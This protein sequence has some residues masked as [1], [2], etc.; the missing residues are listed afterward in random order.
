MFIPTFTVHLFKHS[1]F[2]PLGIAY[3]EFQTKEAAKRVIEELNNTK[4]QNRAVV[5][6]P[7]VPFVSRKKFNVSSETNDFEHSLQ[8]T[9]S[10]A[11]SAHSTGIYDKLSAGHVESNDTLFISRVP[12][13]VSISDIQE[14]FDGYTAS[15]IYLFQ[16]K[17]SEKRTRSISFSAKTRSAII[18]FE[19]LND[20]RGLELIIETFLSKKLFNRFLNLRP[21]FVD[22]VEEIQLNEVRKKYII[23]SYKKE[24]TLDSDRKAH[25]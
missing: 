18:T 14:Y 13:R 12:Y 2:R 8:P 22:K 17:L 23:N 16:H 25:V 4:F 6:K 1:R 10:S 19:G 3:A 21:A 24:G 7:Y 9:A 5:I 20:E 15:A 11:Q